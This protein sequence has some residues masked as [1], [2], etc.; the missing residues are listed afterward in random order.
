M[1]ELQKCFFEH[2]A[3]IQET[4]VEVCMVQHK[5]SDEQVRSML[6][7]VTYEVVT[8]LY[9]QYQNIYCFGAQEHDSGGNRN[10]GTNRW[11][12]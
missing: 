11:L 8:L 10:N 12:F 3:D 1:N 5:C 7:N 2:L 6:Y 4:C 9:T